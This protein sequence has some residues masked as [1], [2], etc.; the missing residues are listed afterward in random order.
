M[1]HN[2]L[3]RNDT[4]VRVRKVV[5][6]AAELGEELALKYS[7]GII[8]CK[9]EI[10]KLQLI[11]AYIKILKCYEP[12]VAETLAEGFFTLTG[13]TG[14][15]RI[16]VNAVPIT[17]GAVSF[18]TDLTT[19]A[20]AIVTATGTL[21]SNTFVSTP[22]YTA[23]NVAA[24]VTVQA[25]A[26]SGSK[27]NR[28]NDISYIATGDMAISTV[29][30]M[31]GGIDAR[32]D[33]DNCFTAAKADNIFDHLNELTGIQFAAKNWTYID[34]VAEDD[35][36]ESLTSSDGTNLLTGT[37]ILP[38]EALQVNIRNQNN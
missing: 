16:T 23:S 28:D 21:S 3:T 29:T 32:V 34:P 1:G 17:D 13:T 14:T 35:A 37:A 26:G 12:P 15:I 31:T 18:D 30:D 27:P 4:L 36:V 22:D 25:T 9:E 6:C 10:N 11:I 5:C 2:I 7:N 24:V 8:P 38:G 19:T 33:A 20:A